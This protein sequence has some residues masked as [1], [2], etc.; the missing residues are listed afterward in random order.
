MPNLDGHNLHLNLEHT[1]L[2]LTREDPV[3]LTIELGLTSRCN[4]WCIYCAFDFKRPDKRVD[5]NTQVLLDWLA[6]IPKPY[7]ATAKAYGGAIPRSFHLA[8]DGEPTCHPDFVEIV[9]ALHDRGFAIGLTTNGSKPE[10]LIKVAPYLAWC[11]FSVDAGTQEVYERI[12]GTIQARIE[13]TFQTIYAVTLGASK[14]TTI[15][16]QCL[17]LDQP[18]TDLIQLVDRCINAEVDYLAFKPYSQHPMSKSK[19]EVTADSFVNRLGENESLSPGH[20]PYVVV[21]KVPPAK[22]YVGCLAA[23]SLFWVAGADGRFYPCA[24]FMGNQ[25]WCFGDLNLQSYADIRCSPR[26]RSI[27]RRLHEIKTSKCRHPCRCD[28]ANRYLNRLDDPERSDA[29]L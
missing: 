3:P 5:T 6:A 13:Q 23:A 19:V 21:R 20:T 8:G 29:F 22:D 11:R 4:H 7:G 14:T 26:R 27:L 15:G 10:K 24:Q 9:Q 1:A 25:D 18:E 16:V 28:H 2:S 12:H 17:I